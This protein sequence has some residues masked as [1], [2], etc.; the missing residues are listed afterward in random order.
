MAPA[1]IFDYFIAACEIKPRNRKKID[2]V[3]HIAV[4]DHDFPRS[5]TSIMSN[6]AGFNFRNRCIPSE[7]YHDF[8]RD[9]NRSKQPN[10]QYNERFATV[11]YIKCLAIWNTADIRWSFR[12]P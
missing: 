10:V 2:H 11:G 9:A 7:Q 8:E 4:E 6:R 1:N 5:E 3:A 12:M